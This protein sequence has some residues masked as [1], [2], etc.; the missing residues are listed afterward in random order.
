[1]SASIFVEFE[2]KES[3]EKA[4]EKSEQF[5]YEGETLSVRFLLSREVYLLPLI[6]RT[7]ILV[8]VCWWHFCRGGIKVLGRSLP[9]A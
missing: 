2:K 1:M 6:R 3:A 4:V 8:L 7:I 5:S 9:T